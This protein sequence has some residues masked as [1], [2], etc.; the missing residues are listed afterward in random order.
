[1]QQLARAAAIDRMLV[2]VNP[3]G[4]EHPKAVFAADF[5]WTRHGERWQLFANREASCIPDSRVAYRAQA[6]GDL[7]HAAPLLLTLWRALDRYRS[8]RHGHGRVE[9]LGRVIDAALVALDELEPFVSYS[10]EADDLLRPIQS[11]N[12]RENPDA[13]NEA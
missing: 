12:E 9:R 7:T 1:M 3:P 6:L 10:D 2:R 8:G 5:G 13:T 4:D 11:D